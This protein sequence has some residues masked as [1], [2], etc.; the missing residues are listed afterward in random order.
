MPIR[1]EAYTAGGVATGVV[2]RTG[3]IREA[4][5]GAGD[6]LIERSRWLPLDGSGERPGGDVR[7]APDDLLLVVAD[8]PESGP[9]HAQWHTVEIDAGPYNVLGE[10]PTMPGFD[11]GRALARPTGE[12]V[13]LR[14]ARIRLIGR[15]DAGEAS[16]PQ[17]LVNRY[18]VD[19]VAADMMLGFFFPGAEM[20]L[21]GTG[22]AVNAVP[23]AAPA[24]GTTAVAPPA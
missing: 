18:T 4:L 23:G 2:A 20:V 19:R 11:P 7:M 3:P 15:D 12:F 14:D 10:M 13:Y 21:T 8:E 1:V 24:V 17:V 16:A 5:D 6:L 22:A 9:V